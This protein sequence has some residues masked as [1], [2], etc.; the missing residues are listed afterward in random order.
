MG[1]ALVSGAPTPALREAATAWFHAWRFTVPLPKE[2]G[3]D[4]L[5]GRALDDLESRLAGAEQTMQTP[6]LVTELTGFTDPRVMPEVQE[7]AGRI[8]AA[9]GVPEVHVSWA[10]V[11]DAVTAL[12]DGDEAEETGLEV[13]R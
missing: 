2:S 5:L 10:Q 11:D 13:E 9:T 8:A 7:D 6:E 3:Y 4:V 12:R 1:D